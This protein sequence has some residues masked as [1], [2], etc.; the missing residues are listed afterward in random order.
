[1]SLLLFG[2]TGRQL[3]GAYHAPSATAGVRGGAVLCPPWGPE[4]L[5]SHR[6][7]RRLAVRLSESGYHVLRFDYY[8]TGDSAGAREEGDLETWCADASAAVDE[9]RDMSGCTAITV[10]GVR[11]GAVVGWRLTQARSDVHTVVL[12]DPVVDGRQYVRD[13]VAAQAEIDRWSLWPRRVRPA[14][15]GSLDLLGFPLTP[16]MRQS[17]EAVAATEFRKPTNAR[18]QVFYSDVLRPGR[19]GLHAALRAAGT[20]FHVEAMPGQTPWREDETVGTGGLPLLVLERMVAV[21]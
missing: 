3:L 19:D 20:P 6:I 7:Y 12:W 8:G 11:L 5:A 15:D 10:F 14:A 21:L 1:M 13:L 17:V 16:A 9:L 4:Y 18:V 2:E